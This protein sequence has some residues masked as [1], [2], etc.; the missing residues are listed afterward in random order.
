MSSSKAIGLILLVSGA[1]SIATQFGISEAVI[2]LT[3]VAVGTSLPE[4]ATAII[5]SLR[6]H[7][8]VVI[9]NILGS[10]LFNILAILGITAMIKPLPFTGQ[11][12]EQDVWLMLAS[13]AFLMAVIVTGRKIGRGEGVLLLVL[14]ISYVSWLY[15]SGG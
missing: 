4:L 11:I 9:G 1:V 13:S 7:T 10:N 2:G 6:R 3:L 5:A 14:Y 15:V 12:A 8:D